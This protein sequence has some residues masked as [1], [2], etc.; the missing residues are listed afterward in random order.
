[1]GRN[2]TRRISRIMWLLFGSLPIR[3]EPI[4]ME[5]NTI[6]IELLD[7]V[8]KITKIGREEALTITEFIREHIDPNC[9]NLCNSCPGQKRYAHRRAK[10]WIHQNKELIAKDRADYDKDPKAYMEAINK[11]NEKLKDGKV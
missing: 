10:T 7:K 2:F 5:E 4:I 9:I 11:R 8:L 6:N 1:M 3:E